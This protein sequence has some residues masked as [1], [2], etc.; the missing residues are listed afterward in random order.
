MVI[1]FAV[2]RE[3]YEQVVKHL[4]IEPVLT[5]AENAHLI[6]PYHRLLEDLEG[7][8]KAIGTTRRGI[9]PAYRDR[10]ARIGIRA[11]DL[12]NRNRLE[13]K[14]GFR[15]ELLKR[16]WPES[17]SVMN[18]SAKVLAGEILSSA[19]PFLDSIGNGSAVIENA[20]L[21]GQEVLFEGAQGAL[22]DVDYGTYPYVTS[23]STVYAGLS[24]AVG[25]GNLNVDKRIGVTK[26]YTTRVGE[27]PFPT[28]LVD[29]VGNRLRESGGEFGVTTGRPRRCGWLDLVA[30]RHAAR[31][32]APTGLAITKLDVLSGL[33]QINISRAYRL[34]GQEIVTFPGSVEELAM[35]EP[36]YETVNGW[37]D[38]IRNARKYSDLPE[39]ARSYLAFI[40]KQLSVPIAIVSVGPSPEETIIC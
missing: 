29:E 12:V 30:L 20:L 24:R 18:L 40:S 21:E 35:C 27:G 6:T 36:V 8:A 1:D 17:E 32:N 38:D 14:L 15:L 33:G 26:A 7:S 34:H 39:A 37:D 22:L 25:I 28:E 2:L 13:E 10:V 4:Q 31:L 16:N 5:I 11:I 3:E 19:K 9:G 23:S